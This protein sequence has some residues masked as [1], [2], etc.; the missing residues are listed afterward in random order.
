MTKEEVLTLKPHDRVIDTRDGVGATVLAVN[1]DMLRIRYDDSLS[2]N[3][4][5]TSGCEHLHRYDN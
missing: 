4:I 3:Y 2:S 1:D 5:H